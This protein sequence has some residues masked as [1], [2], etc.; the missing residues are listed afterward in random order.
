MDKKDWVEGL[1][2]AGFRIIAVVC[3][4]TGA[5]GF[6]FRLMDAWYRF[7][8]NYLWAFIAG[9]V[10][11]PLIIAL[12]GALLYALSGRLSRRMA[13]RHGGSQP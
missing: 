11:R 12:A 2:F 1:L 10:L 13:A 7:D 6:V 5:L 4:L 9:T 3:L 8:P